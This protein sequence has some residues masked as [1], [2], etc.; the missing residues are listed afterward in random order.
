[1]GGYFKKVLVSGLS[2]MMLSTVSF[3]YVEAAESEGNNY[4]EKTNSDSLVFEDRFPTLDELKNAKGD[5]VVLSSENMVND[6]S[7]FYAASPP[8]TNAKR[9]T[10]TYSIDSILAGGGSGTTLVGF[11]RQ[12]L[13]KSVK[14]GPLAAVTMTAGAMRAAGYKSLVVHVYSYDLGIDPDTG[15]PL[16]K[17]Q[18]VT[19]IEKYEFKK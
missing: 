2:C 10:K 18:K 12:Q 15:A 13:G 19:Q 5:V 7:V 16:K 6:N 3:G 17:K 4:N 9:Y 11:I 1:M 8:V 14:L